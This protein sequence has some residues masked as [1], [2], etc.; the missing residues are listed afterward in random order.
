MTNFLTASILLGTVATALM[1]IFCVVRERLFGT[2]QPNYA[3]VGRWVAHLPRGTFFHHPI[4][5]TPKVYANV[6]SHCH[7]RRA[8]R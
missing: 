6:P 3:P 8:M 1:D 2:P 7:P 4:T 5:A